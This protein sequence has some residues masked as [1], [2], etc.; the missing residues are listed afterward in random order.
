MDANHS[1][2]SQREST[3][4]ASEDGYPSTYAPGYSNEDEEERVKIEQHK[5]EMMLRRQESE[6]QA[7]QA[8]E[9][10]ELHK[11]EKVKKKSEMEEKRQEYRREA[12]EATKR[13]EKLQIQADE[14]NMKAEILRKEALVAQQELEKMQAQRKR[15]EVAREE[16]RRLRE[17]AQRREANR[18]R[19][20]EEQRRIIE[21]QNI[22]EKLSLEAMKLASQAA[23]SVEASPDCSTCSAALK[24]GQKFCLQCGT[25]CVQNAPPK[26]N[27]PPPTPTS[28]NLKTEARKCQACS[29]TLKETQ[30][31]C[32][33]CGASNLLQPKPESESEATRSSN[34]PLPMTA[35]SCLSCHS[36]LKPS[37]KFCLACGTK[38]PIG[39][40]VLPTTMNAGPMRL[41]HSPSVPTETNSIESSKLCRSCGMECNLTAKF[42]MKCGFNFVREEQEQVDRNVEASRNRRVMET[43][44]ERAQRAQMSM[45]ASEAIARQLRNTST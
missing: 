24:P 42:C 39:V 33:S 36:P 8:R 37:Q 18:K 30:K 16:S 22:A 19:A 5:T 11:Q 34:A 12:M 4:R 40:P 3:P 25:K 7:R 38:A 23:S 31:F 29:F 21:E 6:L 17:E 1:F 15:R 27:A 13:R 26:H 43:D 45:L 2:M 41:P 14:A 20:E 44:R 32:P 35:L 28:I 9:Q 10:I